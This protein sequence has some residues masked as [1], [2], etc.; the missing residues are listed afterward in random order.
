M[1]TNHGKPQEIQYTLDRATAIKLFRF[2]HN[3]MDVINDEPEVEGFM[4]DLE[5]QFDFTPAEESGNPD[6]G[7]TWE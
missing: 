6:D 7:D 2:I 1:E 3:R 4:L 5:E